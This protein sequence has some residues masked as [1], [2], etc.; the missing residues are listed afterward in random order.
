[1]LDTLLTG[2]SART[3]DGSWGERNDVYVDAAGDVERHT[4]DHPGNLAGAT[5]ESVLTSI[6]GGFTVSAF[7]VDD[8][9][10]FLYSNKECREMFDRAVGELIGDSLFEYGNADNSVMRKVLDTGDP[11]KD[12]ED[13]VEVAGETTPV[14][15]TVFPLF[16]DSGAVVGAL[17][18]NRDISERIEL[19]RREERL[20]AYQ[21]QAV[22]ELQG[23][24]DRLSEGDLTVSP[25]I[26]EPEYDFP[27]IRSVYK[28]FDGMA[29]DL[30]TAVRALREMLQAVHTQSDELIRLESTLSAAATDTDSALNDV[31]EASESVSRLAAIQADNANETKKNVS[32][33]SASIEE[34]TA[35]ADEISQLATDTN[36]ATKAA[37][38]RATTAID[39]METAI[40]ASE[41]NVGQVKSLVDRMDAIDEMTSMIRDIA[42]QTNMLAL[43][44]NIEAARSGEAGDGFAVVAKEIK[45]LAEESEDA[46]D[47]IAGT[48]GD[49]REGINETATAIEESNREIE[50]AADSVGDVVDSIDAVTTAAQETEHGVREIAETTANQ[51]ED[52]QSVEAVV[53]AAAER[54]DEIQA[55]AS[56][57]Q[58]TVETGTTAV[59]QTTESA[60]DLERVAMDLDDRLEAFEVSE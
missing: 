9:G 31:V 4:G 38:G 60:D 29:A 11:V 30:T 20:E 35:T 15:R 13:T 34:I 6:L 28:E 25:S 17:E 22:S 50:R 18:I 19:E 37:M 24:L 44:A 5:A 10:H 32:D 3:V 56:E 51:A 52:I 47:E 42:E 14:E 33:L 45:Q 54:G 43:N 57:M 49:L 12:L 26:P 59:E 39:R 55:A 58:A 36:E 41:R 2:T 21:Q 48:I 16:D 23:D 7:V 53:N 40:D 8:K 27:A 46:V 1:M